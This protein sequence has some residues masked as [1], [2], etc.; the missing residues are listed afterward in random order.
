[1]RHVRRR[2]HRI[3][4]VAAAC[5][6]VCGGVMVST[7]MAGESSG[8][9]TAAPGGAS[10]A[11]PG[12]SDGS[13]AS[14]A[15]G[16]S[17]ASALGARMVSRL[18]TSRTAG[19][20][21]GSDGRPVVAVT[22]AEAA[23]EVRRAGARAKVVHHSMNRLRSATETL[24]ATPRVPG[25]AWS[26]DYASNK[27]VV[28]ADR[29]V[30][31][32]DWSRLS[33]VAEGIG[34]FVEMERTGGAFTTRVNGAAPIFAGNGRC[35]AGFNVTDG[36]DDFILTAGHCGPV[37]TTWFQDSQGSTQVGTTVAGSFPGSDFSLVRYENGGSGTSGGAGVVDIG[38]GQGVRI[39][40]AADPVVGQ[41]VFRS[42]STTGLHSGTVT[43]LNATVN[44]PEGTVTGLIE[45]DVCA[46]PGDSGG[47]LIAQGLALG[48]TSGGNGDCS[49]GGTTFF[50]PALKALDALGV[51]L[52]DP[53]TGSPGD[54]SAA[55][56]ED[57]GNSG[58]GSEVAVPAPP[59]P[60]S[61]GITGVPPAVPGSP[62]AQGAASGM[63][64][65]S[66]IVNFR[67]LAPGLTVIVVSL[68]GLVVTHW[69]R[70]RQ[71]RRRL[72]AY[73]SGSWG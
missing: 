12:P 29:T 17:D 39:V 14:D 2:V 59:T 10:E 6:L 58:T 38:G 57:G 55:A 24:S 22:D 45:T 50:Q 64:T 11:R 16:L 52:A 40:G 69:T 26:V 63:S 35:S 48:V 15:P 8:R 62:G 5:G 1:M 23:A 4:R 61:E 34:G 27:V 67:T 73:Y 13:R 32:D 19:S 42:G 7:A 37:G 28:H 33:G 49:A 72:R 20:W 43:A 21:I 9:T 31:A 3:A 65:L 68:L 36:P 41:Q 18:G 30:S 70:S 44:Y 54:G 56:R 60:S 71:D 53:R 51:R 25:T 66:Q 46:E 47:P